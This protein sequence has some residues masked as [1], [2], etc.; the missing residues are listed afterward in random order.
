MFRRLRDNLFTPGGASGFRIENFGDPSY[1]R[2]SLVCNMVVPYHFLLLLCAVR[3]LSTWIMH[4]VDEVSRISGSSSCVSWSTYH[5]R[6]LLGLHSAL[7]RWLSPVMCKDISW[8]SLP[9]SSCSWGRHDDSGTVFY[10]LVFLPKGTSFALLVNLSLSFCH[11]F[12]PSLSWLT[13]TLTV[14]V[15][16]LGFVTLLHIS[17]LHFSVCLLLVVW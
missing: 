10:K 13:A 4:L 15:F 17:T 11:V 1:Y 12:F 6:M 3:D 7:Q 16:H 8:T 5:L 9:G 14:Q 2:S